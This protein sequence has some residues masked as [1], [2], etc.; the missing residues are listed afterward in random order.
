MQKIHNMTE[1]I[2]QV[3]YSSTNETYAFTSIG[4]YGSIKKLVRFTEFQQNIF[5]LGFGDLNTFTDEVDDKIVSD[6]GDMKTVLA[7]VVSIIETFFGKNPTA[8]IYFK[9][10]SQS[11]TRL[12]QIAIN[13]YFDE[14]STIFEV[15]GLIN[16]E[17]EPFQKNKYYE[18][19][20]VRK[21]L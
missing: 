8:F 21:L 9:G 11:R 7:T 13:L 15:F 12:Y 3:S 2:Y 16:D 18:S 6:N 17:P 20:L 10:S 1:P 14:F 19:F 4:K 5:N